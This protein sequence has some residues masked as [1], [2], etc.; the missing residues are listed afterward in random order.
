MRCR[1]SERVFCETLCG[2]SNL[3]EFVI[4]SVLFRSV[5]VGS[6]AVVGAFFFSSPRC[7]E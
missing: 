4:R 6:L 5:C 3:T 2:V 1:W 7:E